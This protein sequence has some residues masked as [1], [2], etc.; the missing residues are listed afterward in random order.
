MKVESEWRVGR[1]VDE[2]VSVDNEGRKWKE[3]DGR[4]GWIGMEEEQ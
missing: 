1:H 4:N 2:C 3:C